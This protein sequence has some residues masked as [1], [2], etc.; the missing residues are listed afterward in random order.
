VRANNLSLFT[1]YITSAI[2]ILPCF[3]YRMIRANPHSYKQK[4]TGFASLDSEYVISCIVGR[5]VT[6]SVSICVPYFRSFLRSLDNINV[7]L[8]DFNFLYGSRALWTL[9]A[10][11]VS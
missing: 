5:Q 6:M 1:I 2:R 9:A 11:L 4:I 7:N 3:S 8:T 10:F